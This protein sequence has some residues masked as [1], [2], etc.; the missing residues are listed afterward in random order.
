MNKK[1][2][3]IQYI[4]APAIYE[5]EVNDI[6][7]FLAGGITNC[8]NWQKEFKSL[9]EKYVD[10]SN[11]VILN[12]RREN[13]PIGDPNEA[14]KQ[15]KWEWEMFQKA[16][17]ISFWFSRGSLNPIVLFEYG[18]WLVQKEKPL[19]V[20]IDPQYSRKQDVEIQT[21]LER[22]DISLVYS[23]EALANEIKNYIT[24]K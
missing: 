24:K 16:K 17:I 9:L 13:F 12:P 5:V 19:F 7:L 23:L 2:N 20:G 22:K 21:R 8:P 6:P 15:I 3:N 11:L 14:F 10:D 18:K 4:E 1:L